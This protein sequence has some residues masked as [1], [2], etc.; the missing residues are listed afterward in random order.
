MPGMR[1]LACSRLVVV[2]IVSLLAACAATQPSAAVAAE[3]VDPPALPAEHA[4]KLQS[5]LDEA[6]PTAQ[7]LWRDTAPFA[8]ELVVGMVEIPRGSRDKQ[9]FDIAAGALRLDR[10]IDPSVGAYPV[11]YGF[12]P[13]TIAHDGDPLDIL[14]LGPA[15]PAGTLVKG[16]IVGMLHMADEGGF[17]SKV[18]VHVPTSE[19]G[20]AEPLDA[21]IKE[22]IGTFFA[23]YK[24]PEAAAGKWSRFTGWGDRCE[25]LKWIELTRVQPK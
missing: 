2:P 9:E 25:A 5:R 24:K 10:V 17:D 12:I 19:G 13:Q 3:C 18:V 14:V 23:N 6:R 7:N 15:L 11:N 1:S 8:G 4:A 20:G 16:E 21:A 22:Q